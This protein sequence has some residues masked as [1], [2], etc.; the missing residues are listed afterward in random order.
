MSPGDVQVRMN[1][2][3][4]WL[5]PYCIIGNAVRPGNLFLFPRRGKAGRG[6]AGRS[7]RGGQRIRKSTLIKNNIAPIVIILSAVLA[8]SVAFIAF[9]FLRI[10]RLEGDYDLLTRGS[11][12]RNF[13][14]IVN[15]N[16]AQTTQVI[17]EVE[18]LSERYAL[19]IRRMAGTLQ[20]VG[21]VRYDAF[22]DL[23]GQFSFSIALLDDR[24][25]GLVLS[26][27][28]GRSESRSYSKP[29]TERGSSYE[30]SPEEHEA[31]RLAMQSKEYGAM[32]IVARDEE[33]EEKIANLK[34][35][36]EKEV[37]EPVR[38]PPRPT[39]EER[40]DTSESEPLFDIETEEPPE[41]R[42]RPRP[43]RRVTVREAPARPKHRRQPQQRPPARQVER[44]SEAAAER[45][46]RPGERVQRPGGEKRPP[47]PSRL[48]TP[49]E[50][51]RNREPRGE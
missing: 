3:V 45:L 27:I 40:E 24:G 23:G 26:S 51:L 43:E 15:E 25:N 37:M 17:D 41:E 21:I 22:R 36:H 47:S 6:S 49:V 16:I 4:K 12:G 7:P 8:C 28:Y 34:L 10:R 32:P 9:L 39:P 30:L 35:F 48:D 31:I 38:E 19:V 42:P 13:I 18:D 33:H 20:H 46:R 2:Q 14:E 50:R 1:N 29:I 44:T 11:E 5:C